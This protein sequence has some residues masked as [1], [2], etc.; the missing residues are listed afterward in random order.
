MKIEWMA[1]SCFKVTLDSGKILIFD[2][3]DDSI[4]YTRLESNADIVFTSHDHKDHSCLSH[5][6]GDFKVVNTPG[7]QVIDGV[8][9]S[10]IKTYHDKTCGSDKGQNITFKVKA[11]GISILHLGDLGHIPDEEYFEQLGQVDI[12]MI[13]VGGTYTLNGQEAFEVAKKIEPNLIIPMH[14]KT[15]FLEM[16]LDTVFNFTD[17]SSGYFDRARLGSSSFSITADTLKKRSRIIIMESSLEE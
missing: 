7:D 6:T 2:P 16:H 14:Y 4:G 10:G 3:F 1:H 15:L 9:I 8:E 11:E 5:L 13:P 17:A 12:L